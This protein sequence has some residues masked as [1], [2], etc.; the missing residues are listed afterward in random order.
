MSAPPRVVGVLGGMGPD[1]TILFMQR[2]V[3]AV[4]AD[5]DADHT[6]LIVDNNTQVPSR[7]KAL[8]DGT[9]DSPAPV[10]AAM[11]RRLERAGAEA[12]V[13]PCNTAHHFAS[14]ITDS[15]SIPFVDMI[16]LAADYASRLAAEDGRIGV[17]ASP[18]TRK[19]KLFDAPFAERELQLIW[20]R[21]QAAMLSAVQRIKAR[22]PDAAARTALR[23]ASQDLLAQGAVAQM[24]ACSEFSLAAEAVAPEAEVFDTV[25]RLTAATIAFSRGA[26][27]G[28]PGP[29]PSERR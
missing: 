28:G 25:D 1:A 20:P 4:D 10:L 14:A 21:D 24:I 6:P 12:L 5:D 11:A 2:V 9:G 16:A 29:V 18:A 27:A 3:A 19:I 15:V 17:L 22:G 7:I 8:I 13:M 26:G 23:A